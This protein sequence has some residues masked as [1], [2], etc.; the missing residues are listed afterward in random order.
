MHSGSIFNKKTRQLISLLKRATAIIAEIDHNPLNTVSDQLVDEFFNVAC[1]RSVE[2]IALPISFKINV[3]SRDINHPYLVCLIILV[4]KFNNLF[5]R[6]LFLEFHFVTK[7]GHHSSLVGFPLVG[8]HFESHG[9]VARSTDQIDDFIETPANNIL[10]GPFFPL[11]D[12][13]NQIRRSQAAL[14]IRRARRHQTS[15]FGVFIINLQNGANTL[16]RETHIDI[17]IFSPSG[18]KIISMR[19]ILLCQGVGINLENILS[20]VLG[21]PLELILITSL[22]RF[23]DLLHSFFG[24]YQTEGLIFEPLTPALVELYIIFRPRHRRMIDGDVFLYLVVET[25]ESFRQCG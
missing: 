5:L 9:R 19:I 12:A 23:R 2:L 15:D 13:H 17:E 8:N 16:K 7:D 22:K 18:R 24:E 20:V 21:Q 10:D 3:E 6:C 14:L 4:G 25:L 11:A 1:R